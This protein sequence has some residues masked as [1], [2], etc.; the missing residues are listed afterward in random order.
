MFLQPGQ[1]ELG[2]RRRRAGRQS[3]F[4]KDLSFG[5]FIG[6]PRRVLPIIP[7]PTNCR[8]ALTLSRLTVTFIAGLPRRGP[9]PYCRRA[10]GTPRRVPTCPWNLEPCPL[11]PF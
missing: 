10:Y 3:L 6:D 8:A 11:A 2:C 4:S 9:G 7:G 5:A 1:I